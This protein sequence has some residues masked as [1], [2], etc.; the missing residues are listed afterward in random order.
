MKEQIPQF[1]LPQSETIFNYYHQGKGDLNPQT[2]RLPVRLLI[3]GFNCPAHT[4]VTHSQQN[5]A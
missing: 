5:C 2:T 3:T 1:L 4:T